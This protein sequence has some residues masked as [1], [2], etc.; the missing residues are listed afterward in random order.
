MPIEFS[1]NALPFGAS[2]VAP[3]LTQRPAS[4]TSAVTTISPFTARSA[5]VVGGVHAAIH[6]DAFD[7]GI[8]RH[9]DR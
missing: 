1:S 2:T 8:A 3:A 6:H 5:T 9:R 7:H 4:G